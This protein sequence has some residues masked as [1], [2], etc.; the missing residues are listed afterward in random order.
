[1]LPSYQNPLLTSKLWWV[2]IWLSSGVSCRF[3]FF[4]FLRLVT[5][6]HYSHPHTHAILLFFFQQLS[7]WAV[8]VSSTWLMQQKIKVYSII[9]NRSDEKNL[10]IFIPVTYCFP[11]LPFFVL[12]FWGFFEVHV[13]WPVFLAYLLVC[14]PLLS[15]VVE[16]GL[17][18]ASLHV[19]VSVVY[20][21]PTPFLLS[22]NFF[23][24]PLLLSTCTQPCSPSCSHLCAWLL[25]WAPVALGISSETPEPHL[26]CK[27][28][29]GPRPGKAPVARSWEQT[30]WS[31]ERPTD[32]Q[33]VIRW[34]IFGLARIFL[35]RKY[36]DTHN[37][38]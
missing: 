2:I 22:F 35:E 24:L 38:V 37:G 5:N 6:T 8:L 34:L 10:L 11:F 16:L 30:P 7:R 1:M 13:F 29:A 9:C 17:P 32:V 26:T 15:H 14:K 36:E 19:P 27:G 12:F 4:F 28:Q 23:H 33:G 3:F 20:F 31:E 25:A 21:L 18:Q